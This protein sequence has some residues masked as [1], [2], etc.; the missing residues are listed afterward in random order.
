MV[1]G[2][3]RRWFVN[4]AMGMLSLLTVSL[5][6]PSMAGEPEG[7]VRPAQ[8]DAPASAV[9]A[10]DEAR[11]SLLRGEAQLVGFVSKILDRP[12]L[13]V[14]WGPGIL[15]GG[16]WGK[17]PFTAGVDFMV[18]YWHTQS[19]TVAL[20]AGNRQLLADLTREDVTFFLDLWLRIQPIDWPVR[21]YI[22]GFV[23]TKLLRS[24]YS[25]RLVGSATSTEMT[26]DHDWSNSVG[27]GAGIDFLGLQPS[28]TSVTLGIRRLNGGTASFGRSAITASREST[29]VEYDSATSAMF[30]MI[31]FIGQFGGDS[32]SPNSTK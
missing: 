8:G 18:A 4:A 11:P 1:F 14:G 9:P 31:G 20:Q 25:L 2:T 12:D 23:G 15:V 10:K 22:E 5:S 30:Y 24:N 6:R 26:T 27:W 32:R 29:A 19:T 17:L 13:D 3:A 28:R 16:G 21:P 7:S